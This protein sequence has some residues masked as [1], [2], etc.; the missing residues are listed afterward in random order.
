MNEVNTLIIGSGVSGL[1]FA[2]NS[3]NDYIIVE[4]EAT[5][6]GLC[7]TFYQDGFVWDYAGHFFHFAHPEIKAM[8]ENAVKPKDM[9]KCVKNTNIN[10]KGMSIDY[11][12][13]MNI[14]ELPKDEFIDCLY[15]LFHRDEK[16]EYSSF[17]DMLY[18]KFGKSITEK[19][20]K[21]YN[22]KLYACDLNELDVDAMGRFFPYA[23]PMQII[24]NMKGGGVKTYN[25][26]FDYPKKGAQY[27]VDILLDKIEQKKVI[28][29][30]VVE[31]IDPNNK[32]AIVNGVKWHYKYLINT[33]PLNGFLK[34]FP[35]S[36][37]KDISNVLHCNKV[38]VFNLG[39]D[40]PSIDDSVHW[41]YIPMKDVNFYRVGYYNNILGSDRLSMY[42]EIGFKEDANIDVEAQLR[43]TVSNLKKLGI[44]SNHKLVAYN[45]LVINPGYVHITKKSIEKVNSLISSLEKYNIYTIG[46]YGK[47]TY[48]SIEDCMLDA[49]KLAQSLN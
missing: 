32:M 41:T 17:E 42:V 30:S 34:L 45:S 7:R 31:H 35:D 36:C 40:K 12:F 27:F 48:C 15:D 14:H 8:F 2:A 39:F 25:S 33:S 9:V 37:Y 6:G 4:K 47:W 20:L 19:F 24:D 16:K 38:L 23:N 49:M 10:Y 21:P 43:K 18:G 46:R 11:P 28:Y 1:T 44:I 29:N 22:E 5:P 13:Q 3:N 26:Q